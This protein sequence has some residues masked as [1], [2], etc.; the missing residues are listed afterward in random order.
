MRGRKLRLRILEQKETATNKR[1]NQSRSLGITGMTEGTPLQ[2]VVVAAV[3]P[4]EIRG[5]AVAADG[6]RPSG[7]NGSFL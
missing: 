4:V 5:A 1:K 3:D 7:R 6:R 2:I